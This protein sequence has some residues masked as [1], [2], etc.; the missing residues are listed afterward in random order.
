MP[1]KTPIVQAK[2]IMRRNVVTIDGMATVREA[3][4]KMRSENVTALLVDKRHPKDAWG[5]ITVSDLVREVIAPGSS[6]DNTNVY[7]IMTKPVITVPPDM[8]IRYV[9]R[10]L[11]RVGV[12]KAP[13]VDRGELLGMISMSD[14]VLREG[15]L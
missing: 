2:D 15:V 14:L 3:I 7:E 8:D 11:H 4:A 13:V 1:V 5:I 6:P 10:L 12:R 9:A